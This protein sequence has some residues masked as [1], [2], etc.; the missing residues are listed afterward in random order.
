MKNVLAAALILSSLLFVAAPAASAAMPNINFN[1]WQ[2]TGQGGQTCNATSY[3]SSTEGAVGCS[4]CDFVI[5]A[6]NIVNNIAVPF[7]IIAAV[8]FIVFGAIRMMLS[9]GSQ[10]A[11]GDARKIMTSAVIGL[12]IILCGWLIVNTA[13]HILAGGINFPWAQIQC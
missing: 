1:I 6:G 10:S 12:V 8:A 13:F 7:G 4:V 5:V 11:F 3:S 9:F 2:G